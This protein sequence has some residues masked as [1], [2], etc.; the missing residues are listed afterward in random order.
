MATEG[1]AH[2]HDADAE[3]S[4]E[5]TE[6]SHLRAYRE[7]RSACEADEERLERLRADRDGLNDEIR[8]LV[9]QI[10]TMRS[11]LGVFDRRASTEQ[12]A[13]RPRRRS[14]ASS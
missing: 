3:E 2:T 12:E 5:G 10:T 8:L 11:A 7:L 6:S 9:E 4:T 1:D 14:G 13:A